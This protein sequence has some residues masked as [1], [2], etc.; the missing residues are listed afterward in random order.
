MRHCIYKYFNIDIQIG[1]DLTKTFKVTCTNVTIQNPVCLNNDI[2]IAIPENIR[3]N[4]SLCRLL[5]SS[6]VSP[7]YL[8]L[9]FDYNGKHEEC[10]NMLLC[11]IPIM[12]GSKISMPHTA[13]N[14]CDDGYFVLGGSE[15][16]IVHQEKKIDREIL[17]RNKR[18]QYYIPN[19]PVVWWLEEEDN[20]NIL[21]KSKIGSCDLAILFANAISNDQIFNCTKYFQYKYVKKPKHGCKKARMRNYI[22]F[23]RCFQNKAPLPFN[24]CFKA[25]SR[26]GSRT[27]CTCPKA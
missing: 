12:T 26:I 6:L 1:V 3:A 7:V 27:S 2:D 18:C 23:E 11:Y 24:I 8:T 15:K 19:N 22:N 5:R 14:I 16:C 21:I 10:N 20:G 4:A 25:T 9:A 17:I 13:Y